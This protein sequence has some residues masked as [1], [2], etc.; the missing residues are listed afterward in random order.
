MSPG[1]GLDRDLSL[2]EYIP[3]KVPWAE[4]G[5]ELGEGLLPETDIVKSEGVGQTTSSGQRTILV[6]LSTDP[7][8]G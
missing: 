2:T 8:V 6:T 7:A 1:E 3:G 4:P 5:N